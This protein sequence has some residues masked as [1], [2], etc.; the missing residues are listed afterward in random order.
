[1]EDYFIIPIMDLDPDWSLRGFD[2]NDYA[3]DY[4]EEVLDVPCEYIATT[5][6]CEDGLEI[7]LHDFEN[8]CNEDWYIQ[9]TRMSKYA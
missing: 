9:L 6:L 5:T 8:A 7:H 2:H 4:C 1:M 3:K